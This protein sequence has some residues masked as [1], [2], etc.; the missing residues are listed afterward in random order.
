MRALLPVAIVICLA[1]CAVA[2]SPE[3]H[4][5]TLYG[6]QRALSQGD[7]FQALSALDERYG[8]ELPITRVYIIDRSHLSVR[9]RPKNSDAWVELVKVHSSWRVSKWSN[10]P[11]QPTA[12]RREN[13]HMS[14]STFNS[15]AKLALVRGG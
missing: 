9:C 7:L 5:Y 15:V 2:E 3:R 4:V 10:N 8:S 13:F 6:D 1:R 14:S 11:L 12:D